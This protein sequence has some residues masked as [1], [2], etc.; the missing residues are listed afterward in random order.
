MTIG[1]V[2]MQ[3]PTNVLWVLGWTPFT[4]IAPVRCRYGL[5]QVLIL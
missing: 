2:W 3:Q 4:E 5:E 1:Y